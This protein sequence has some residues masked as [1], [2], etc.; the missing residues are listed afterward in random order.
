MKKLLSVLIALATALGC[1]VCASAALPKCD[2]EL[3]TTGE[4]PEVTG[5][6]AVWDGTVVFFESLRPYFGSENVAVTITFENSQSETL[7]S[8]ECYSDDWFWSVFCYYEPETGRVAFYYEDSKLETAYKAGLT[9]PDDYDEDD[10]LA[11]LPQTVIMVPPNLKEHYMNSLPRTELKYG[12]S[13]PITTAN[14]NRKIVTFTPEK[15]GLYHFA[16]KNKKSD[17]TIPFAWLTDASYRGISRREF[18][19]GND[20]GIVSKLDASAAYCLVVSGN[21]DFDLSVSSDV[22]VYNPDDLLKILLTDGIFSRRWVFGYLSSGT[23][24][25]F[26]SDDTWLNTAKKNI[27]VV[28]EIIKWIRNG[29]P[30]MVI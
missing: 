12:E 8:W 20:F 13:Q 19:P 25:T 18:C 6:S 30:I 24:H 9:D 28:L 22:R 11:T 2:E 29:R 26:P 1:A 23:V 15:S 17:G 27:G 14:G 3:G 4:L 7:T 5:I 10:Y 21:C 16:F